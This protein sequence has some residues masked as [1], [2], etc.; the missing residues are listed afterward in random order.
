MAVYV[1]QGV[2]GRGKD[3]KGIRDADNPKALRLLLRK[4][5][6]LAT[7]IEEESA[8]RVRTSRDVDFSRMF[9]RV[10][11]ADL[12][13]FTRQLATLLESG[14][15]LVEALSALIEQTD[16]S[17]LKGALTQT[18]DKVNEGTSLAEALKAHPKIF[19]HLYVNMVAAAEASGTLDTVLMRLAEFLET[20]ARL[21]GRVQSALAYPAFIAVM[22]V[23]V[24]GMMM[25][26][27]VPKVTAIFD[28]FKQTLPW[29]TQL[30][31]LTSNIV[32]GYWWLILLL[33]GGGAFALQR[34]R[35]T[36]EGNAKWDLWILGAP[37]IGQ[38]V[39]MV[40]VA[41]FSSTLATLLAAG[42]PMLTALDIARNVLGNSELVRVVEEARE[43]I[44]EGE[45]MSVTF[46]RSGRFPPIVTHMISV[47]ERSGQLEK[48]LEHVASAYERQVDSRIT[49][50]MSLLEPIMIVTMG[51]VSAWIAFSILMP[52]TSI[53][54]MI[55]Q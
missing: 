28:S 1:W 20:Q 41:R 23:G 11:A 17:L 27:V 49:M 48:M 2:D 25:T 46:K 22:A 24:I 16:N 50:L 18:R 44:R 38:M 36:K 5:G 33:V 19:E 10:S 45:S 13:M 40:A 42:V 32:S 51:G 55:D 14:V 6:I 3:A 35:A 37:L 26:V 53:T 52:L 7:S 12:G 30:L 4:E 21:V 47:G 29:Y 54:D 39:V 34:W 31:I 15:P 43:A 8:A 9:Q